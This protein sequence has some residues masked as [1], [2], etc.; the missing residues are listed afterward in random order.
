MTSERLAPGMRSTAEVHQAAQRSLRE[1]LPP[2]GLVLDVGC[3]DGT[4]IR[5]LA[6]EGF[7]VAGVEISA[8]LVSRARAGGL[9]VRQ[10]VAERLPF[11]DASV[12]AIVCSV[13]MPYTDQRV[14]LREFARVVRPGGVINATY[15]GAGYG[16]Q[17]LLSP[18]EG[19]PHRV[20]GARMLVNTAVYVLTGRRLPGPVGDTICQT[21]GDMRRSYHRA[22]LMLEEDA[23]LDAAYGQPRIIYHRLRRVN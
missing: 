16:L 10:G 23:T 13:V 15:H 1:A 11:A 20:Y 2:G 21:R 3:G 9:D 22:G 12:D 19:F 7:A 6:A 18:P 5:A 14:T 17:Y 4:L 8:D